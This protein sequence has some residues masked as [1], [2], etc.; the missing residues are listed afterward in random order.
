M[1]AAIPLRSCSTGALPGRQLLAMALDVGA[2]L[3]RAHE[4][5]RAGAFGAESVRVDHRWHC[6]VAAA[7][8][9]RHA[10]GTTLFD[11]AAADA[12]AYGL[13][14]LEL[15]S[16]AQVVEGAD[17]SDVRA[18]DAALPPSVPCGV[19]ALVAALCARSPGARLGMSDAV[20]CLAQCASDAI[21]A[22]QEHHNG[23]DDDDSVHAPLTAL[24]PLPPIAHMPTVEDLKNAR[25]TVKPFPAA[26]SAAAAASTGQHAQDEAAEDEYLVFGTA[27]EEVHLEGPLQ[28]QGRR[29]GLWKRRHFVVHALKL[30]WSDKPASKKKK[31]FD[32]SN[33]EVTE[34]DSTSGFT[35]GLSS[36]YEVII[37]QPATAAAAQNGRRRELRLAADSRHTLDEWARVLRLTI[38]TPRCKVCRRVVFVSNPAALQAGHEL[39]ATPVVLCSLACGQFLQGIKKCGFMT[40]VS[41]DASRIMLKKKQGDGKATE[42]KQKAAAEQA[43]KLPA[44]ATPASGANSTVGSTVPPSTPRRASAG[45]SVDSFY[46]GHSLL[47]VELAGLLPSDL[48]W[49]NKKLSQDARAAS[50]LLAHSFAR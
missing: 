32:L 31:M 4:D 49:M 35:S 37:T 10:A 2:A 36:G 16:G 26:A 42:K 19:V 33:C 39:L 7:D 23:G 14:L 48:D 3:C 24:P 50:L 18:V 28:K 5:G 41:A 13:F 38:N 1:D 29:S 21:A 20:D 11:A 9:A 12:M 8:A 43:S 30:A 17:A 40:D 15:F 27:E 25:R 22:E 46:H 34:V 6:T 44:P 45:A 47:H